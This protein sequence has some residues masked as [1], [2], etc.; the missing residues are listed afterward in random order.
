[1]VLGIVALVLAFIPFIGVGS[2]VLGLTALGLGIFAVIK[3]KGRGQ[4]IAG[5][6]C[7]AVAILV[8][9]VVT[10]I[11]GAIFSAV[12]R[13]VQNFQDEYLPAEVEESVEDLDASVEPPTDEDEDGEAPSSPQAYSSLTIVGDESLLPEGA[14][15]EVS[16]VAISEPDSNTSFPF[17][18]HNQTGQAISRVEIS[19]RAVDADEETLGTGASHSVYPNVVEPGGYAFGYVYIDSSEWELPAGAT[20]PDPQ[21]DFTEGIGSFE[22][23]IA[24]D[25]EN[26]EELGSGDL[27]G[28]V[29]NPHDVTVSGP[30]SVDSVC[31]SADE[32]L[33]HFSAFADQDSVDPESSSTWTLS[34]YR[35]V[36]DCSV[37]LIGAQGFDF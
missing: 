22:N 6:I 26:F 30:I 34:S 11:T 13:E 28:D 33:T 16:I 25:I 9:L 17:I 5:I 29:T 18:L 4:G 37:R 14:E 8:A 19:G 15:G 20:I 12:D 1:M 35:D 7:G 10:I 27:T 3:H 24:L 23:L 21:I 2:F 32:E 36:P 31:F